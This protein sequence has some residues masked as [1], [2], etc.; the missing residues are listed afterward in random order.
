MRKIKNI[1]LT[2]DPEVY[3][4]FGCSPHNEF[5]L[6]L[7]FWEDGDEVVS[8]WN[9]RP[10]LQSYPKVVHGG[11][12]STLLDEIAGW[13]VYVKCGTVGV[14]AEMKVRFKQPLMIDEGQ[15]TIRA[16]L[17]EQNSRMAVIQ[18]RLI[19]SSGKVCAEAELRFF[20]LS[21]TDA[22]EKYN[23]PGVDAFFE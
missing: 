17:L 6:H 4:C 20:L 5:G 8:Y 2:D 16:K 18:S 12:Q 11:I 7:E 19:N 14:T 10:V 23:Y 1:H 15:L 13:L 3:Q 22:R 9:P 21:E